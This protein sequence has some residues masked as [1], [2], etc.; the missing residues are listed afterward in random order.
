MTRSR[1]TCCHPARSARWHGAVAAALVAV[2]SWAGA[3]EIAR[4]ARGAQP[5]LPVNQTL[6]A[7][8]RLM[9]G[10]AGGEA[11]RAASRLRRAPCAGRLP[12]ELVLP[13]ARATTPDARA[14]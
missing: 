11:L 6:R 1:T 13:R 10:K 8:A 2:A 14:A 12:S 9:R 7:L 5:P 3:A 4:P